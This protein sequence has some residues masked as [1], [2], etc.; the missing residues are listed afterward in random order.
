MAGLTLDAGALIAISRGDREVWVYLREVAERGTGV[1]IPAAVLAQVWR[2]PRSVRLALLLSGSR[3][4]SLTEERARAA[5][6]LC[7]RA[8]TSDIVDAAVVAGA[9]R[10]GDDILTGDVG[11]IRRLASAAPRVGRVLDLASLRP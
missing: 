11:D 7:G 1:T 5:G 2:G 9:A 10:R 4:D 3:V 6:E 8:R